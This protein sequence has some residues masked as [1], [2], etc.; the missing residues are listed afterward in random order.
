MTAGRGEGADRSL[1][2][3]RVLVFLGPTDLSNSFG[4]PGDL[5][6]PAVQRA[7]EQV[8][9]AVLA[10]ALQMDPSD[11]EAMIQMG[12]LTLG[13]HQF[14]EALA[15]G[16]RAHALAPSPGKGDRMIK[17]MARVTGLAFVLAMLGAGTALAAKGGAGTETL[18]EHVHNEVLF[19]FP[20]ENQ[21]TGAPGV[22]SATAA[23]GASRFFAAR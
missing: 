17:R 21:C 7:L 15:W 5:K 3:V 4:V 12:S 13:R 6:H 11:V 8:T 16:N 18:T 1:E 9:E 10:S 19:S 22:L 14:R 2:T 20:L 23:N